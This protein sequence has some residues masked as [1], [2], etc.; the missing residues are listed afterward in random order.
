M[1][2]APLAC[3]MVSLAC[4]WVAAP[5]RQALAWS[6]A[7]YAV[8]KVTETFDVRIFQMTGQL[9]SGHTLK[10]LLA[11]ASAAVI[12]AAQYRGPAGVAGANPEREA[13]RGT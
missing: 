11:A 2:A 4:G 1:Q 7:L 6:L 10:H 13:L 12:L 8:A 5:L 3:V 9:I